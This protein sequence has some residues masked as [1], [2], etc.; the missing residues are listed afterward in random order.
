[1]RRK[2]QKTTQAKFWENSLVLNLKSDT[3]KEPEG[4]SKLGKIEREKLFGP[5][6]IQDNWRFYYLR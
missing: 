5:D 2:W 1:M 6:E 3:Y 4:G